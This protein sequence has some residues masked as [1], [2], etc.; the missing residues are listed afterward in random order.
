MSL[1]NLLEQ[2]INEEGY[3]ERDDL[4]EYFRNYKREDGGNG[5]DMATTDKKLRDLT[6]EKKIK[7]IF[8]K[9]FI[10]AYNRVDV[11][12]D[13]KQHQPPKL[14]QEGVNLSKQATLGMRLPQIYG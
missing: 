7:P 6:R 8:N 2:K 9:G 4:R 11:K 12:N 1:I 13:T 14:T 5:F 3:C 10:I